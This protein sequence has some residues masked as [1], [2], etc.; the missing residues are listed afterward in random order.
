MSSMVLCA[1]AVLAVPD[2]PANDPNARDLARMQ[3]DWMV[4]SMTVSGMKVAD[5]ESQTLFRTVE[6]D[7]YTVARFMKVVGKGTFK[8]DATKTPKTIDS[9]PAAAGEQAKSVLG[10]YEFDGERLRICNAAPGKPRPPAFEA[11]LGTDRTMIAWEAE[12]K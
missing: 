9:F 3:G 4:A 7:R 10:I 5:D 8:I 11:G 6:G 2:A 1:A 12:R